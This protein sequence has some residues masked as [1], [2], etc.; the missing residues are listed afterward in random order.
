MAK[1]ERVLV[2]GGSGFIAGYCIVRLLKEGW[3]VR[4]TVRDLAYAAPLRVSLER[5]A[6]GGDEIEIVAAN[7]ESDAGWDTAAEGCTFVLHVASPFPARDP[8]SDEEIVRPARDGALRVLA[9]AGKAGVRRVVM[10]SSVAAVAYGRGGRTE[11][12]TE[13][14]WSDATNLK[15]SSP[16]ERSKTIAEKAAWDWVSKS[17]N[18]FEFVT[19]CP[20]AVL[21][22]VFGREMSSSISIV[23]RLLDGS[24]PGL[25]RFGWA[26]VDVR[27]VAELHVRAMIAPAAA[28]QRY[29]CAGSF[30]WF[31]DIA[32]VLRMQ[33]PAASKR[34]PRRKLPD[35]LV[36]LSARFDPALRER[37]Y[38]LG[39]L[40]PVSAEK[41]HRELDWAPRPNAESIVSTAQSLID[42]ELVPTS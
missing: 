33:M 2:T 40:R 7:L 32:K 38:E 1:L 21:G 11:P 31:S 39:K 18:P 15:D 3:Q 37:I 24:L 14:D 17:N 8:K 22:P 27:D 29:I 6:P 34:V 30:I 10:T 16:Y 4:T 20:G 13:S 41:A 35:W 19:I 9:A 23:S 42:H 25:P 12:F 26:M 5:L 28:G 36:R